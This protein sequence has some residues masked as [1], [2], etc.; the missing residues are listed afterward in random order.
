MVLP[1]EEKV[2][3]EEMFKEVG[4]NCDTKVFEFTSKILGMEKKM[5]MKDKEDDLEEKVLKDEMLKEVTTEGIKKEVIVK[6]ESSY[7][8]TQ[9]PPQKGRGR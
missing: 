4:N 9:T 3:K 2:L 1:R 5:D 8:S 7:A 6:E